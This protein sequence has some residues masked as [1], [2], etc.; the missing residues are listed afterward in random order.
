[1]IYLGLQQPGAAYLKQGNIKLGCRDASKACAL[2]AC[3]L[4]ELA[5]GMGDC[6]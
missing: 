2:G 3:K 6:R 5:K 4:L 1:M